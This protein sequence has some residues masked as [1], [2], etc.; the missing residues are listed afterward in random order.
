MLSLFAFKNVFIDHLQHTQIKDSIDHL[1]RQ[2]CLSSYRVQPD[3]V[4]EAVYIACICK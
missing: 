1:N 2:I 3:A 4:L